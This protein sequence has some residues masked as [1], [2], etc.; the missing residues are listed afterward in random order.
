MSRPAVI[1]LSLVE[2]IDGYGDALAEAAQDGRIDSSELARLVR[3]WRPIP[4]KCARL[5]E[6]TQGAIRAL[7]G[8]GIYGP[9]FGRMVKES[10][11]VELR[12]V[13]RND[14]PE[15][16]GPVAAKKRKAA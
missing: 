11:D 13:V 10:R 12:V 7:S 3:L 9:W 14:D 5:H 6:S 16:D 15:P 1:S 4:R 8:Q 2:S